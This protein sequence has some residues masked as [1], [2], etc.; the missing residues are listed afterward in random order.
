MHYRPE[1]DGLRAV[2]VLPVMFFHAGFPAFSGGFVGVDVFFVISG[3]LI[4]GI[5]I[6]ELGRGDYSILRFYERRARRILPA[7]SLVILTTIP[8]VW[9]WM[10]PT[11]FK[12]FSESVG[13][14]AIFLSNFLFL[15]ELGY[16]APDTELQPLVH[17]WSL[18]IEEQFYLLFPVILWLAYRLGR[19]RLALVVTGTLC[20]ASLIL[21]QS[22]IADYPEKNFFFSPSRFWEILAGAL[23]ALGLSGRVPPTSHVLSVAGLMAILAAMVV[24][25][26]TT[27]FPSIYTL[28]PVVGTMLVLV[29]GGNGSLAAQVLSVKAFVGI[30][31][32]SY[33]AYLWHQPLFA[34]ARLRS[35]GEPSGPIMLGLI[36]MSLVLAY[37]TWRWVETPFRRRAHP[38]YPRT[39]TVVATFGT[40]GAAM[41]VFGVT[42]SLTKG[43]PG[44]LPEHVQALAR[45]E[46]DENPYLASC[47]FIDGS[48]VHP[49]PACMD[50]A[51][52]GKIEVILMGDSHSGAVSYEFQ[53]ELRRRGI[54]SY[55]VSEAGCMGLQRFVSPGGTGP[56]RCDFYAQGMLDFARERGARVLVIT[57]RFP[58]YY[59][60][61]GF[62]NGEGGRERVGRRDVDY[63]SETVPRLGTSDAERRARVLRGYTEELLLLMAEFDVVLVDPIPEAGW[64]VPA[65]M[66]RRAII[67]AEGV[68]STPNQAYVDRTRDVLNAFD[69]A[70]GA[71]LH[72]VRMD[73][74]FCDTQV[75]GRCINEWNG[76]PLY[77]DDDHLSNAGSR[78]LAPFVADAVQRALA[79]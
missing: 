57:S 20:L 63:V 7:L 69:A 65:T 9:A 47:Q 3:Y 2:A 36:L 5:L 66:A 25:N 30:G 45:A 72:R 56:G 50:Y 11:E 60:G 49:V 55:A 52:E 19:T 8:F 23:V 27:P 64:N 70:S 40:L 53:N 21:C 77:S 1:V 16:F 28:L 29:F 43:I 32:V 34:Y 38:D 24:F 17:L 73:D 41:F 51:P 67:N 68:L 33:S 54:S 48:A 18:A 39:R 59:H 71:R 22:L 6:D 26:D 61:R 12:L 42:G 37:A 62:D 35:Q 44:R 13:T 15:A 46:D 79:E 74:V 75:P 31:L 58:L 76:V 14:A 4:T 10:T 78:L